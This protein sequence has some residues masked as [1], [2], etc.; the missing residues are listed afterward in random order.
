MNK[1]LDVSVHDY[2]LSLGRAARAASREMAKASTKAKNDALLAMATAIREQRDVL[3]AAN[4]K[5]LAQA[6]AEGLDAAMIDRLT[7]TAK[8]VEAMA[9]GLV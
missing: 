2:M 1:P 4:E 7:L 5:D 9:Q 3:L 6:R 8:G